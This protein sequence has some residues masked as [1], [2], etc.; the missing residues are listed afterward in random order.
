MEHC[1]T[2]VCVSFRIQEPQVFRM[3]FIQHKVN[4]NVIILIKKFVRT[5]H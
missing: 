3:D 4:I 2:G 5:R 1:K